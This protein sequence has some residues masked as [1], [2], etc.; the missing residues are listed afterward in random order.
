MQDVPDLDLVLVDCGRVDVPV[1]ALE[2]HVQGLPDL[3]VTAL[4]V[5]RD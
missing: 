2:G 4:R 3:V 5:G 1:A